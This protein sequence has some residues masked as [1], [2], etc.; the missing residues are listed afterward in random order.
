MSRLG[1]LN[2]GALL[3]ALAGT[4]AL[5]AR[6]ASFQDA[7]PA[8]SSSESLRDATGVAV[9]VAPYAR[10]VS[11]S[12]VADQVLLELVARDR[13]AALTAYG[14]RTSP[15]PWRYVGV[16]TIDALDD[17]E[18]ILALEPDLVVVSNVASSRRV[19]RLREA[20][21]RVFDLGPMGGR[22]TLLEDVRQLAALLAVPA[23]GEALAERFARRLDAVAPPPGPDA[24]RALYVQRLGAELYGGAA[25]TSYHDVLEAAGLRDAAAEAGREGW[26]RYAAE[27]LL[28]LDPD[29]LVTPAGGEEAVC[30]FPGLD[31]LRA[32]R[33]G[34]V[35]AVD[36]ALLGD[37]GFGMLGAAE[38]L[39]DAQA[40]LDRPER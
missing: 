37:P 23:R 14:A 30:R 4:L 40:R 34:R 29:L 19:A 8:R 12:T 21:L 11:A 18:A 31:A 13:V 39:V 28:A 7:A 16:P 38:A 26:P 9:P 20:G 17:L 1:L 33:G 15:T 36:D 35:L 25:G 24:P 2:L 32:C 27:E 10:V 3:A 6:G 5:G 22:G